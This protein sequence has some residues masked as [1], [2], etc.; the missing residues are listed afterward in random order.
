MSRNRPQGLLTAI[1]FVFLSSSANSEIYRCEESAAVS[2]DPY[3]ISTPPDDTGDVKPRDWIVDTEQGWRRSD[4]PDFR[5]SCQSNKGYV[6]CRTENIAFGE[7]TL[8][9]HPNG[10]SFVVVY[11][12]Y[13]L[14]ALAFVG[15]CRMG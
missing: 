9:I 4:F 5:G 8:S 13:G 10:S 6:V 15:K 14:G 3:D 7:A 12:D 1:A 11:M 2:I